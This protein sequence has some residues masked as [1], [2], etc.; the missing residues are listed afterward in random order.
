MCFVTYWSPSGVPHD[1]TVSATLRASCPGAP[2][3]GM[4]AVAFT[5]TRA[6]R[7]DAIAGATVVE[8]LKI[9]GPHICVGA[10]ALIAVFATAALTD[11]VVRD[12]LRFGAKGRAK[13]D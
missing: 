2:L 10:V 11:D 12:V 6:T 4:F 7:P 1:H 9:H 8:T 3:L 5:A 13:V